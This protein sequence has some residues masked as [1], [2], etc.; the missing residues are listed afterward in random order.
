[1]I[2]L[3]ASDLDGTLIG[4]EHTI[5][6]MNYYAIQ[7]IKKANIS[8]AI[9]S[10]KTY[11]ILKNTCTQLDAS[12]G[13]FGNGNQIINLQTGEEIY[14]KLLE[15]PDALFC[16]RLAKK[17][18]LH[19]HL[20]TNQEII[21]EKLL[22]MDLRNYKLQDSSY[23][24]SLHFKIVANIEE[25]IRSHT[26]DIYKLVISDTNNL[27]SFKKEITSKLSVTVCNIKK[28]APY[29]DTII[30]KEYEYLDITPTGVNKNQALKVLGN[31]LHLK[32]EEILSIGDNLNDLEMIQN[33][34]IGVAVSNA[35]EEVKK[36]AK[37]VTTNTVD[38]GAFAEAVYKF[39]PFS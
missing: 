15:V 8:F 27:S 17:N 18:H 23:E 16:T 29:N 20:Y 35:Y 19:V 24:H 31:Y 22:Y 38:H 10:G 14:K 6:Q 13:I 26:P 28:Y 32:S 36:V 30:N 11:S 2:K 9:C 7:D 33:S 21:S 3:V 4:K 25:Y 39:I 12:Y 5:N 1:M 37:F 34:G